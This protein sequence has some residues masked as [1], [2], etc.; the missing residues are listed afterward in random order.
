MNTR[1]DWISRSAAVVAACVLPSTMVRAQAWPTRPIHLTVPLPPGGQIDYFARAVAEPLGKRL[2]QPVVVENR[3]GADGRI[4]MAHVARQ[5]AVG[6]SIAIVSITNAIHPALFSNLSYDITRD[7]EPIGL[8]AESP[9]VLVVG[10]AAGDV[11][12]AKD[13]VEFARRNPG[14]VTYGS[15]GNGTPF[16]LGAEL[17]SDRTGVQMLHV[18]YRG[19]AQLIQALV[20]GELMSAVVAPGP[21]LPHITAGRIKALATTLR[22]GRLALLPAVPTLNETFGVSTLTMNGW[23]GLVAPA[24]TP[25]AVVE[26]YNAELRA[27]VSDARFVRE[28]VEPQGYRPV[29]STP[30][31]MADVIRSDMAKYAKIVADAK[32]QVE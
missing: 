21:Y 15:S 18:P 11:A 8:I 3:S 25:R 20:G 23:Q 16:H 12:N 5:P 19:T 26:R 7:F 9:M 24:G 22:D 4:G 10:P 14:K 1:R 2:G 6:Y 28:K 29:G 17:L 32:I 31:Q 30:A 27:I 13:L